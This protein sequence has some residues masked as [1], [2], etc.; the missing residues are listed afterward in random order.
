MTLQEALLWLNETATT[1][2]IVPIPTEPDGF[3]MR[4]H[5]RVGVINWHYQHEWRTGTLAFDAVVVE[6]VLCARF[7]FERRFPGEKQ[8]S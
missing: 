4:A 5:R 3:R 1:L 8:K 7:E 6:F 2:E